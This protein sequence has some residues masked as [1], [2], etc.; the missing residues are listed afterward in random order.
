TQ[1]DVI[2][3]EAQILYNEQMGFF[4][5]VVKRQLQE[6]IRNINLRILLLSMY[7]RPGMSSSLPV[8]F[9]EALGLNDLRLLRSEFDSLVDKF[10]KSIR[11]MTVIIPGVV[12]DVIF[13]M[14][15]G[16][17]GLVRLTLRLLHLNYWKDFNASAMLSYLLSAGYF[18]YVETTR[19]FMWLNELKEQMTVDDVN[20]IRTAL[21]N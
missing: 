8:S 21:N 20:F 9:N 10:L 14:T 7:D 12:R 16:H 19:A 3:D 6:H 13:N 4:W 2:I 17:P 5:N 11:R 15:C 18:K 1:V